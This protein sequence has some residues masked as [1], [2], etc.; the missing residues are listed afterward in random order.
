MADGLSRMRGKAGTIRDLSLF[1]ASY[2]EVPLFSL[3]NLSRLHNGN[4]FAI[5]RSIS[6]LSRSLARHFRFSRLFAKTTH[7]LSFW[8]E[9]TAHG[10]LKFADSRNSTRISVSIR[11]QLPKSLLAAHGTLK[12]ADLW[13]LTL[14]SASVRQQLPAALRRTGSKFTRVPTYFTIDIHD[15]CLVIILLRI[16]NKNE[17]N[18]KW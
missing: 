14:I 6:R 17:G 12:F 10:T 9:K 16:R 3:R 2:L 4:F 8:I 7:F 15:W 11:Q 5:L 13:N 1:W 18:S